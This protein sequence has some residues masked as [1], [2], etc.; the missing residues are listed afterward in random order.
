[1]GIMLL[2]PSSSPVS[3]F[4]VRFKI[5]RDFMVLLADIV[6]HVQTVLELRLEQV[7]EDPFSFQVD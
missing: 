3:S 2:P 5:T 6:A 4:A 1:M 7:A